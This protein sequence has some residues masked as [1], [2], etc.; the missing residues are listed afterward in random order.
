MDPVP[1]TRGRD[2]GQLLR[3]AAGP[4]HDHRGLRGPPAGRRPRRRRP[5]APGCRLRPRVRRARTGSGLHPP[6]VLVV[7]V[8]VVGPGAGPAARGDLPSPVVPAEHLRLRLLGPPD[9]RGAHR[10]RGASSGPADRVRHRRAPHRPGSGAGARPSVHVAR[11]VPAAGPGPPRL[12]ASPIQESA[13]RGPGPGRGVDPAATGS[14]RLLGRDSAAVGVLADRARRDGLPARPSRCA[15]RPRGHRRLH[16]HRGRLQAAGGVPVTR[17]GHSP[18]NHRVGGRGPALRA[19]G[20]GARHGLAARRGDRSVRHGAGFLRRLAVAVKTVERARGAAE[21]S[22][23]RARDHLLKLQ[24]EQG[25]WKGELET[26]VTMDA[27]DLRAFDADNTRTL[28]RELPFCDFGEVIDP[29][30]ADVTAHVV[31]MLA[32]EGQATASAARRGLSWL[33]RNQE[34]DGSWFGRWGA[35]H[36]YGTG[37][38]VPAAVSGG[39]PP[40]DEKIRAAVRWLERHQNPDGGWGEDLRS[41][42]DPAGIGRGGSTASQTA[43]ALLALLAA[44]ERSAESARRG[45]AWLAETQRADGTWDEPLYTGTGFPGDFYINYHLYRLVFPITALG[46]YLGDST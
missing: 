23:R 18:G 19:S 9:A 11:E 15:R 26:N 37:A 29:P 16:H 13:T 43:W 32:Y 1:A 5:H 31:E 40:Q 44:G 39:I 12:R 38:V 27:E 20:A 35:N 8:V 2:V 7:R 25:W 42:D 24:H 22:L 45:V 10:R 14:R 30:S 36:V 28:C 34:R 4:V 46:R 33:A 41:Y 3:R 6:V 21:A 17:V